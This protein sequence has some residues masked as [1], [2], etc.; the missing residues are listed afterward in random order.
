MATINLRGKR[1]QVNYTPP[2]GLRLRPSFD[3]Y[4]QA[5]EWLRLM[6]ERVRTGQDVSIDAS[7]KSVTMD[8]RALAEEVLNRHWRG[9][10]SEMSLWRN[11][12]DVYVR[13][14][15]SRSVKEVDERLIDDLI[16]QLERDGKSNGTINRRLAAVSKMLKHAYRRGYID[17]M[18]S[19][20]RKREP[21]G[22]MRWINEQE[23]QIMLAKF[24]GIGRNE[25]ADFCEVLVDTGL[26][27]GELFK[28]RGRD[29]DEDARVIYLWDTKNGK[30][31]SVPLTTRALEALRRNH[32]V[33]TDV[34]LFT[35]TQDSFSHAWKKMKGMIGLGTDKEFIPHCLR[36]T[37]AS[38]LVQ[39]G[40]DLR[41]IQEF[42][43]H[44]S[45]NTTV[46]YAKVAPK[47]LENAR[48]VL[49]KSS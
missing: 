26:R 28:L 22:R 21:E 16:Y 29:V 25:M 10:K 39:R 48:D 38:R 18:P 31:R 14:G 11:A 2:N 5:D 35:F 23:E 7:V 42:L 20:E 3:T 40:V 13:L 47:N 32:K 36:H 9:C 37:C 15:A 27:T 33:D 4:E 45:I 24:R 49:E 8:L 46:R 1:F 43:G 44:R 12:K 34:P 30:S 6:K 19:I 17:R 41:V